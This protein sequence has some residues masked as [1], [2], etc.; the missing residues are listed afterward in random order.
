MSED[1]VSV[2]VAS[3]R[4]GLFLQETIESVRR[5]TMPVAE[6][7]LVD[8]GSPGTSLADLAVDLG[9]VFVRQRSL[10]VSVA[11][12]RGVDASTGS[13]LIFLDDDDIWHPERVAEQFAAMR[14]NPDAVACYSGLWYLDSLGNQF[15]ELRNAS[16][17]STKQMMS[18]EVGFPA[19]VVGA[20][21]REDPFCGD[22]GHAG[23]RGQQGAFA[24]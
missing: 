21:L 16:I 23:D 15:G 12:N 3:N 18:G 6:I 1:R 13:L 22:D 10:G 2:I 17:G 4:T 7:V 9:L 5:Q 24:G 19:L 20:D 11:R 8:D 14:N